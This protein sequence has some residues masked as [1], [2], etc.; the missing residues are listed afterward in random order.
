M[1]RTVRSA[2]ALPLVFIFTLA[3]APAAKAQDGAND[4]SFNTLDDGTFGSGFR[5]GDGASPAIVTAIARQ[6]DGRIWAAGLFDSVH[7]TTSPTLAR[8]NADGSLDASFSPGSGFS[9]NGFGSL[10]L[11]RSIVVQP[12]G[13]ALVGGEFD[14]YNGAARQ[15]LVRLLPSGALDTSFAASA[16]NGVYAIALQN[17]GKLVIGGGFTSVGGFSRSCVARLNADGSVDTS[18]DPGDG[19]TGGANVVTIDAIALQ[20]DGRVII[21]G[22]FNVFDGVPRERIARLNADGSL[23]TSFDPG[24]GFDKIVESLQLQPD[25]KVLAGGGFR[26]VDGVQRKRVARLLPSGALDLSFDP[27]ISTNPIGAVSVIRL[28]ADGRVLV[29]GDFFSWNGLQRANL[30][31]LDANGALD[32]TYNQGEGVND[33]VWSLLLEPSGTALVAGRFTEVDGRARRGLARL[34]SSGAHATSFSPG[35]GADQV[36]TTIAR[37]NDGKLLIAGAFERYN[38]APVNRIALLNADGSVDPSFAAAPALNGTLMKL[39]LQPNGS[40]YIRGGPDLGLAATPTTLAR[41]NASGAY[42][43]SFAAAT[44]SP[45]GP[46]DFVV[47]P[48]GKLVICG[49]FNTVGGVPRKSVARLLPSGALDLS[50]DAG[51]GAEY[52]PGAA[53]SIDRILLQPDGKLLVLGDFAS[54]N[55][56]PR[57]T[58]ARLNSDGSLDLSFDVGAGPNSWMVNFALESDGSLLVSGNFTQFDGQPRQ[59]VARLN[60]DGSVDLT[61]FVAGIGSGANSFVTGFLPQLDGSVLLRGQFTQFGGVARRGIARVLRSG[62]LD[63][64]FDP[65]TGTNGGISDWVREPGGDLAIVGGFTQYDGAPRHGIA[66]VELAWIDVV[67]YCTSGTSSQGCSPSISASGVASVSAASGFTLDVQNVDGARQ[68]LV[69]YG[70]GGRSGSSLGAGNTS[71]FCVK[72]PVQRMFV[73][74]SGGAAGTCNGT[75]QQDWLAFLNSQPSALGAPFAAGLNVQAQAWYRDPPAPKSVALSNALEFITVP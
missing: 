7:G 5:I 61:S 60:S 54:F 70:L 14:Q 69:F 33:D 6:S 18:F 22:E 10:S 37:R 45:F 8:L 74:N 21:A 53:A 4:P 49:A 65:G 23:D 9:F 12:D 66:R 16:S 1:T 11:L 24:L 28:Q 40:M 27:G 59:R 41:L 26:L 75:L 17:D 55:G 25:G 29:G 62:A 42:D 3:I 64:S 71:F 72:A 36:V 44:A 43:P 46:T 2:Q 58:L 30:V 67:N 32:L 34:E 47:Q 51:A 31:R 38:E 48:D 39:V 19:A 20:P 73:Q 15:G 56:T 57:H 52:F 50:F 63:L 13:R 35:R 68:G